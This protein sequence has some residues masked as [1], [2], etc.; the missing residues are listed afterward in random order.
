MAMTRRRF[1]VA[2]GVSVLGA[3]AARLDALREY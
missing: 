2:A 3:L 1:V